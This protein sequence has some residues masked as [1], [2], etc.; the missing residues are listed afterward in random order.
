M[1]MPDAFITQMLA[2]GLGVGASRRFNRGQG[3][4][5]SRWAANAAG[6]GINE[7]HRPFFT[8]INALYKP[9]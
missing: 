9:Q 5:V 2:F 4:N 7:A 6:D 3:A 8:C 1:L